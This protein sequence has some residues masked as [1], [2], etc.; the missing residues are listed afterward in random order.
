MALA[1]VLSAMREIILDIDDIPATERERLA[2]YRARFPALSQ[3]EVEDLAKIPGERF[4]TYTS[5]IFNGERTILQNRF[6]V[7]FAILRKHW[8]P[9]YREEFNAFRLVRDLHR[10]SPWKSHATVDLIDAFAADLIDQRPE[11]LAVAPHLGEVATLERTVFHV[12]ENPDDVVRPAASLSREEYSALTV[13]QVMELTFLIPS[14]ARFLR[15]NYDAVKCVRSFYRDDHQL[16]EEVN[17]GPVFVAAARDVRQ[18]VLWEYLT[19]PVY[20]FLVGEGR[21]EPLPISNLAETY[22]ASLGDGIAESEAFLGFL[23]MAIDLA[24]TGIIIVKRSE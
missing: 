10:R 14:C 4:K 5:S 8:E 12:H 22:L 21:A 7:S 24:E 9:V 23:R 1:G 13:P 6:R 11:L 19:E 3:A 2:S 17:R 15:L 20:S 16:G 18:N